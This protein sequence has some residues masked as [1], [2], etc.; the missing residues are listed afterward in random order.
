MLQDDYFA[1]IINNHKKPVDLANYE[2][3]IMEP[4]NYAGRKFDKHL[5]AFIA[6]INFWFKVPDNKLKDYE[7]LMKLS[8]KNR[9]LYAS[10]KLTLKEKY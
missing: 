8:Y 5:K 4:F 6:A 9:F 1:A 10:I 7:E 3:A 2:D